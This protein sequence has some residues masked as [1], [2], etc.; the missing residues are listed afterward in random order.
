[1]QDLTFIYH[2]P[3]EDIPVF[4]F[5]AYLLQQGEA[6]DMRCLEAD[7]KEY[8]AQQYARMHPTIALRQELQ[9]WLDVVCDERLDNIPLRDNLVESGLIYLQWR[10]HEQVMPLSDTEK[11]NTEMTIRID[12]DHAIFKLDD[13]L[14]IFDYR[15]EEPPLLL[16]GFP[17]Q[18]F[19]Y[20][21]CT[22]MDSYIRQ[23][24]IAD[25]LVW[26]DSMA[27]WLQSPSIIMLHHIRFDIPDVYL[28]YE[29]YLAAAKAQWEEDNRRRYQS[30]EPQTRC[31][32]KRLSEQIQIENEMAIADLLPYLSESQ[33]A[34]FMVYL[35]ECQQYVQ[36]RIQTKRKERSDELC[37]YYDSRV[38]GQ[39]RHL[40]TRRLH[41]AATHPTAP[42]AELARVV[43]EM[44]SQ[45]A[46]IA[47][48]RPF[49]HF[50]AVINKA[51]GTDI[52]Y[53]SFSK[54]FRNP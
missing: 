40:I 33:R 9:W 8:H 52:K 5:I 7:A 16:H 39:S 22:T 38:I 3:A 27:G 50:I 45:H 29:S 26:V 25:P 36:D 51:F 21:A 10:V 24:D 4:G 42:A 54:H 18:L 17:A 6:W 11:L 14:G 34:A 53:D 23:K 48:P 20:A 30:G 47:N 2:A 49:T 13:A 31:F 41:E 43:Q 44:I 46:L 15:T 1:M 32:M 35:S 37:Q 28:L 19:T 12:E